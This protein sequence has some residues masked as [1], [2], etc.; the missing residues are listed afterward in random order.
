MRLDGGVAV[1][2][3]AV[4]KV[5]HLGGADLLR[6]EVSDLALNMMG[7]EQR[8]GLGRI[9]G[10][11][12]DEGSAGERH[13]TAPRGQRRDV[14]GHFG[15]VNLGKVSHRAAHEPVEALAESLREEGLV[16]A[17][18]EADLGDDA[19]G[20]DGRLEVLGRVLDALEQQ[21][22][23]IA[24]LVEGLDDGS[25]AAQPAAEDAHR[26]VRLNV[27]EALAVAQQRLSRQRRAHPVA[28]GVVDLEADGAELLLEEDD[29]LLEDDGVLGEEVD[30]V[31]VGLDDDVLALPL[32]AP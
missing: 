23:A 26:A 17:E 19:L 11:G 22:E 16:G 30:V 27:L 20:E 2:Q 1:A 28:L 32:S 21:L 14:H 4:E 6:L 29:R 3:L 12:G 24:H 10:D 18:K 13:A 31:E 9:E 8:V 15:D 7:V 5:V 25:V